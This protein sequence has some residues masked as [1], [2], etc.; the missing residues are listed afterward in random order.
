M[1]EFCEMF[2]AKYFKIFFDRS[3]NFENRL[4]RSNPATA[5]IR[6]LLDEIEEEATARSSEYE[7]M[8]KVKLLT[9]L[10]RPIRDYDYVSARENYT[11]TS[12]YAQIS[13][14]MKFLD[15][16]ISEEFTLEDLAG[17]ANLNRTYF[18]T[19]FKKLNG[20]TPW[21]YITARRVELAKTYLREG[22]MSVLQVATTC[23]FNNASNFNRAF[24]KV[25]G[26]PPSA[27]RASKSKS[28]R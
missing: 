23:G 4:D 17:Q 6:R 11:E 28:Q 1:G 26:Q 27:Y 3:P 22:R 13:R 7:L 16:N 12:K 8:I 5:E 20:V 9:I 2:D 21:E 10:V 18:I 25:T 24:K 19:L 15:D 14:A